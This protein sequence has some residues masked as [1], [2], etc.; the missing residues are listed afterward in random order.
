MP[1]VKIHKSYKPDKELMV[2]V[3]GR[4]VHFGN[5]NMPIKPGT[6]DGD[7]Y[8]KRSYSMGNVNNPFKPNYWSRR[9]WGCSGYKSSK[10]RAFKAG[11]VV[12]VPQSLID[13]HK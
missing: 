3:A 12:H 2:V 11:D 5:P 9:H 4:R 10:R 6:P 13:R 8:C 7:N 1:Y